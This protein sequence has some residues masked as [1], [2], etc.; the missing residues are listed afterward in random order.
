MGIM[1]C[2]DRFGAR[3]TNTRV[4]RYHHLRHG[5]GQQRWAERVCNRIPGSGL[6]R[7]DEPFFFEKDRQDQ[8]ERKVLSDKGVSEYQK[9]R[10]LSICI[11]CFDRI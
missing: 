6:N 10:F 5:V 1:P 2:P 8:L 4:S 7:M 3:E 11:F 9:A